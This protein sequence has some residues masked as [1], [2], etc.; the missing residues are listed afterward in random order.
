MKEREEYP[1]AYY[2]GRSVRND[3]ESQAA[4]P[5]SFMTRLWAWWMAGW[6]DRDIEMGAGA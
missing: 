1:S 3:G 4:N 2:L 5:Y 6:N